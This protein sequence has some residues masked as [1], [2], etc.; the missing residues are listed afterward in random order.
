MNVCH[1]L[2]RNYPRNPF[3][4]TSSA[5]VIDA[6][7]ERMDVHDYDQVR[8]GRLALVQRLGAP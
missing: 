2:Y 7:L 5:A 6:F 8:Q 1:A 4:R 3:Y